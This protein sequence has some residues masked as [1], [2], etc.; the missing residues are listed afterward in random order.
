MR[1]WR[2]AQMQPHSGTFLSA[3][4]GW[5]VLLERVQQPQPLEARK[6][7]VGRAQS[8][9][10]LDRQRGQVRVHH[11]RATR[12]PVG[13]KSAQNVPMPFGGLEQRNGPLREPSRDNG[14]R[15]G[16]RYR[17]G[18]DARVRPNAQKRKNAL[19]SE[20]DRLPTAEHGLQPG[21]SPL[22]AWRPAI[23]SVE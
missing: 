6:V 7:A 4:F 16:N 12:L 23:V 15:F 5:R 13:E 2:W 20:S 9:A 8:G 18:Q 11:Q 14:S 22:L 19:P 1:R 10:M 17:L 21:P 3:H